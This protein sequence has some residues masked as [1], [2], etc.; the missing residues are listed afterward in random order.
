ME[1]STA[2]NMW[3]DFLD[4]HLEYAF[5]E[6]PKVMHF[7]DNEKDANHSLDL[8][9]N[10]TKKAMSQSLLGLQNR[11]EPL[12]KIGSFIVLTDWEGTAKCIVKTT[13]VKLKPLFS[14]DGDYAQLEGEGDKSLDQWKN[15]YWN[16]FA[17]ELAT[18]KRVPKESMIVV[19][20]TF[21]KV[22]G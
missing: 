5:V 7:F 15:I 18:F 19:C 16:Y 21:E 11:N 1:N 17:R 3:G 10:K 14:I 4:A 22:Y 6:A 13:S 2:R 8:V 20:V 12:P 9:I